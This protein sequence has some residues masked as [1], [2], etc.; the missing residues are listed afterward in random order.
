[1]KWN[2]NKYIKQQKTLRKLFYKLKLSD[3]DLYRIFI[4]RK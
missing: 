4:W 3:I 2:H 1:M